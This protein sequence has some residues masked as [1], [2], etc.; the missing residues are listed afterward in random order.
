MKQARLFFALWPSKAEARQTASA[1]QAWLGSGGGRLIPRERMHMTLLFVGGVMVELVDTVASSAA[2]IAESGFDLQLDE[3]GY[4][5]R[6]RIAWLA[7]SKPPP[8]LIRLAGQLRASTMAAGVA[9]E[10]RPFKPH[11]TLARKV[12]QAPGKAPGQPLRW[13][14]KGFGLYQSVTH[15]S[16]PRYSLVRPFPLGAAR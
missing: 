6:P 8:A 3:A 2:A 16:G 14:I 7:P 5:R 11:V 1:A 10:S 12:T 15:P 9:L 4:W 13:K